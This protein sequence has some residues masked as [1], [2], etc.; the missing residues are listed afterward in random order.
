M[1]ELPEVEVVRAGLEPHLVGQQI[2]DVVIH[3]E[4]VLK[5]HLGGPESFADELCNTRVVQACRRG[6]F[7]WFP[8]DSQDRAWTMHLGMSGQALV[9]PVGTSPV[10]HERVTVVLES[11][12]HISYVDQRMFG[13]LAIVDLIDQGGQSIP[14]TMTHVARDALDPKLDLAVLARQI[15][16]SSSHIK[17]V[18]LN[19]RIVSGV[20]NIYADEALWRNK[21][22][23]EQ[24][25]DRMSVK[26]IETLL[27]HVRDVMSEALDQGGTSFDALY[28]NVN[29]MSGYFS[30]SLNVY[31]QEDKPCP[32]C[33]T[34]IDR[35]P[36]M[37]RSSHY[38]RVCQRR[39]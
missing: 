23:Y 11:G 12:Q 20:G 15:K 5:R 1:P 27:G 29:G 34:P 32:R 33:G 3:D 31:G 19:Q 22:H 6:K 24:A 18:L 8:L 35:A 7:L 10:R 30:R 16:K 38:C 14:E 37:N 21:T 13:G 9:Q 26:K 17:R 28:V 25:A 39:R 2:V 4:R 36:F